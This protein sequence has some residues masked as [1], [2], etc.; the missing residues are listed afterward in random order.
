MDLVISALLG[1]LLGWAVNH[2]A[3]GAADITPRHL[4]I[5]LDGFGVPT[6]SW[7]DP[8]GD[9]ITQQRLSLSKGQAEKLLVIASA[10]SMD[11][12]WTAEL[13]ALVNGKRR[14]FQIND[15]GKPFRTCGSSGLRAHEW[16]GSAWR[17]PLLS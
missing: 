13:L 17:P 12:E 16:L 14:I 7:V 3:P 9:T 4:R 2:F 6:T 10:Q 15:K 1:A 5:D 8:E 11:I